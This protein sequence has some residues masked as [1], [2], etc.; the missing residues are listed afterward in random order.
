[1]DNW[2]NGAE[3]TRLTTTI[4]NAMTYSFR[5]RFLLAVAIFSVVAG[6]QNITRPDPTDPAHPFNTPAPVAHPAGNAQF[7]EWR[8]QALAA[9]FL[10]GPKPE[11]APRDFGTFQAMPGVVAHRVT[12]GTQFGMR[13]PAIVYRPERAPGK[14]PAVI[15][16]AGHGGDKSTW[17]EVYAG[18]LYA[19]AGA[20][21][22]TFDPIGEGERNAEHLHDARAHDTVLPGATSPARLGGLMIGDVSQA[23]SYALSLPE[24]DPDRVAVLGYSMGSFHA[25]LA[26]GLDPRIHFLVLS[27]GGDL[28]GNG[29]SMDTNTKIM[30]QGGPYQALSLL[31]DKGAILYALHQRAGET[32]VLNG[33]EDRLVAVSHHG[34]SFFT[35][36]NARVAALTCAAQPPMETR[37]YAGVGHRPSWVNRDAAAWLNARLLFP[38]WR[39]KSID[40][41]GET[42][43]G[44]WAAANGAHINR[45]YDTEKSE[46]GVQAVGSNFPAPATAQLLAVPE[47]EWTAH[48]DLYTWQGWAQRTLQAEGLADPVPTPAK[49]R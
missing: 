5:F 41:L 27:G 19:G 26:A 23:V 13:V 42:H 39:G 30:C 2:Q 34:P 9:L 31:P 38:N 29:G 47:P 8:Q 4:V 3:T 25:A 11:L 24:V 33:G 6:A 49:P 7:S 15:V 12:Y 35:D 44:A 40:S 10:A 14:L 37:F 22:V 32:L 20:V 17:Y 45:G 46:A 18:L 43:I 21:V 1:M 16:V 28:D 36:L 48:Q